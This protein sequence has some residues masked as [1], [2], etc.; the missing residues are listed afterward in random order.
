MSEAHV[1]EAPASDAS[2]PDETRAEASTE[3]PAPRVSV[4]GRLQPAPLG[5]LGRGLVYGTG[6][7]LLRPLVLL[8]RRL[9]AWER[10]TELS[11]EGSQLIL[12][13]EHETLGTRLSLQT[14]RLPTDQIVSVTT[15]QRTAPEPLALGAL[16]AAIAVIW[17]LWQIVDGLYGRSTGMVAMGLLA[18]VLGAAFDLG[19]LWVSGFLPGLQRHGVILRI[20][21][22]RAI[23]VDGMEPHSARRLCDALEKTL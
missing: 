23:A 7:F 19:M 20:R 16:V 15:T 22:G 11:L 2:T 9:L 10:R 3:R 6:L 12:E 8:L 4:R 21:D 1:S 18:L 17:G 14:E 5:R 13:T